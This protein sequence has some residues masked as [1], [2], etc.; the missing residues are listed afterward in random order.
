[1]TTSD[2]DLILIFNTTHFHSPALA[3]QMPANTRTVIDQEAV[4]HEYWILSTYQSQ[5]GATEDKACGEV[6]LFSWVPAR[7]AIKLGAGTTSAN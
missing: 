7:L 6:Q 2:R 4:S 1:M 5:N 3:P